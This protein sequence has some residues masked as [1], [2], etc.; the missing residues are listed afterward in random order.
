MAANTS[1]PTHGTP[2][3][4]GAKRVVPF[5]APLAFLAAAGCIDDI[6]R[7]DGSGVALT[8]TYDVASFDEIEIGGAFDAD[9][10][11]Q[12]GEPGVEITV[13]DNLEDRVEVEVRGDRLHVGFRRGSYDFDV[14]P[15]AV[16]TVASLDALEVSGASS[17]TVDGL[18]ADGFDLEVSGASEVEVDGS[19]TAELRVEGSGASDITFRGSAADLILDLSGAS[20]G[21]FDSLVASSAE[22]D[23]SGASDAELGD[24]PTVTGDVSGASSLTVADDA[25]VSVDI[26]GASDVERR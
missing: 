18:E 23:L 8:T 25:A 26:S 13:D 17:A 15:T 5:L 16:I 10:S 3:L 21:D 9:I 1:T 19:V 4:A 6:N 11:I 22:I 24:I 12:E 14:T 20:S 2:G 7:I